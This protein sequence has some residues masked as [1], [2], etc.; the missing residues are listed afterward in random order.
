[1]ITALVLGCLAS[2][3]LAAVP[4]PDSPEARQ[5]A[6]KLNQL[7][8]VAPTGR[9]PIDHSGRNQK[10]RASFYG[11]GF[12]HRKMADGKPMNPNTNVVASKTLPLGTTARVTNLDNGRTATVKVG[13]RGP[14]VAG[15]VVDLSPKVASDLDIKKQGVAPVIVQPIAVPQADGTVQLGAGA[16]EA[17]PQEVKDATEA[18]QALVDARQTRPTS[19]R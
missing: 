9:A 6:E 4:P 17:S 2:A 18:S 8:P 7:P 3:G 12:A 19:R 16:A 1:M 10:G 15:R 14:H 5:Q 11:K 13:D